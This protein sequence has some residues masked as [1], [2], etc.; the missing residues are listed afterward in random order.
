MVL[1]WKANDFDMY[2][3]HLPSRSYSIRMEVA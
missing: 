1:I 2:C 3:E